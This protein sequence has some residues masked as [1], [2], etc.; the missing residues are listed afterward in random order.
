MTVK[1]ANLGREKWFKLLQQGLCVCLLVLITQIC[2]AQEPHFRNYNVA[3][4]LPSSEVY[5]AR[6]GSDGKIWFA[7]D[8]GVSAFDGNR[9]RNFGISDGLTDLSCFASAL[10]NRGNMWFATYSGRLFMLKGDS[11]YAA[12]F[13][14]QLSRRSKPANIMS[15]AVE[16]DTAWVGLNTRS[17]L[18]CFGDSVEDRYHEN[19]DGPVIHYYSRSFSWGGFFFGVAGGGLQKDLKFSLNKAGNRTTYDVEDSEPR[20]SRHLHGSVYLHNGD[21]LFASRQVLWLIREGD[22]PRQLPLSANF[23][24]A[25]VFEDTQHRIWIGTIRDGVYLLDPQQDFAVVGHYLENYSVSSIAQDAEGGIWLTTLESGVFYTPIPDIKHVSLEGAGKSS[26]PVCI[27]VFDDKLFV[28]LFSGEVF[29]MDQDFNIPAV[30]LIRGGEAHTMRSNDHGLYVSSDSG[31]TAFKHEE[32]AEQICRRAIKHFLIKDDTI[33]ASTTHALVVMAHGYRQSIPMPASCRIQDI[34]LD[35]SGEI[36]V[37]CLGGLV[38][39]SDVTSGVLPFDTILAGRVSDIFQTDSLI[40]AATQSRGVAIVDKATRNIS[41][42]NVQSG[43][44]EAQCQA[45]FQS[46]A[47]DLWVTTFSGVSKFRSVDGRFVLEKT[48]NED[49]G[50]HGHSVSGMVEWNGQ[51]LIAAETGLWIIPLTGSHVNSNRPTT[52]IQTFEVVHGQQSIAVELDELTF[53]DKSVKITFAGTAFRNALAVPYRYRLAGFE[54]SFHETTDQEAYYAMLPAGDYLFEVQAANNEGVWS[55]TVSS[56]AF[57]IPA[58]FWEQWWFIA[59]MSLF[60]A[61]LVFFIASNRNKLIYQQKEMQLALLETE[62]KAL[63][64]QINPHFLYNSLNSVQYF[65]TSGQTDKAADHIASFSSLMRKILKNTSGSFVSIKDEVSI[66]QIYLELEQERYDHDFEFRID[67][68]PEIDIDRLQ[69]P[70]MIIQPHVENAIWHGLMKMKKTEGRVIVKCE[71][72]GQSLIWQIIDNGIGRKAAFEDR[73]P[74]EDHQSSGISL[75][76]QRLKILSIKLKK[77]YKLSILDLTD[78]QNKPTGTI[79]KIKVPIDEIA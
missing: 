54:E 43:L 68:A 69:I 58:P 30:P 57:S 38:R 26:K 41:W 77:E 72:E 7:T 46:S 59:L 64:S 76:E 9:F 19:T 28:G 5:Q 37:A 39:I 27:E 60:T 18:K 6:V 14:D 31:I 4:G 23:S 62:Q 17:E 55:E 48:Y 34:E 20:A 73:S 67:I 78:A 70:S 42:L 3:D 49:D 8:N 10:D 74:D 52:E 45:V 1:L 36:W 75:T 35:D 24:A 13:N 2:Y 25:S 61:G 63:S 79:V 11:L 53:L 71:R 21:A 32:G 12:P 33:Y 47:E 66:L 16:N 65:I 51:L 22:E 44:P 29:A 40:F 56:A 15:F 50:Y